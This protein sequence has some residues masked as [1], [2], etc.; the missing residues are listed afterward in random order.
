MLHNIKK[1]LAVGLSLFAI[2]ANAQ[3]INPQPITGG[4]VANVTDIFFGGTTNAFP[5]LSRSGTTIKTVLADDSGF[6]YSRALAFVAVNDVAQTQGIAFSS[7]STDGVGYLTNVG[8]TSF[9]RLGLGPLTNSFPAIKVNGLSTEF[10]LGDDSEYGPITVKNVAFSTAASANMARFTA[11]SSGV[12][13]VSDG[14]NIN[15]GRFQLGGTTNA[16]PS[17]KR[18]GAAINFRLA[19]DSADAAITASL[20][21]FLGGNNTTTPAIYGAGA[22]NTGLG[23]SSSAEVDFIVGGTRYGYINNTGLVLIGGTNATAG[24]LA[25]SGTAIPAGGTAGTGFTFSST[26][27]FGIFFGS[28]VPTLSAAKGSLYLRSDGT[29]TSTRAYINTDGSTTWTA[30]TTAG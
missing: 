26:S 4:G 9:T 30:I 8:G 15:F 22:T 11:Q 12:L 23:L 5:K 24:Y 2:S 21:G 17:I 29:S 13:T 19:D 7:T 1:L 18:N 6:T 10:K 25:W 3:T 16:Y 14:S 20:G 27:N 28:G